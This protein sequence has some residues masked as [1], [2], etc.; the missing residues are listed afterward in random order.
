MSG[1]S[2]VRLST[3]GD[4]VEFTAARAA[5]ALVV[6]YSIP[7]AG[8]ATLNVY[9]NDTFR[10]ALPLTPRY[11]W[12]Y[13]LNAW[14]NGGAS[15]PSQDPAVGTPFHFF[16]EVRMRLDD[17]PA[18]ARVRLQKDV[19]NAAADYTIDLIDL[20]WAPPPAEMPAGFLS[21]VTDCGATPD[22]A[23]DDAQALA[24]CLTRGRDTGRGVWIPP[25]RFDLAASPARRRGFVVDRNTV[26]GAGMWHSV[27]AGAGAGFYCT[28]NDCRF[29]DFALFGETVVRD[30]TAPDNGFQGS[31]GTGSALERVWIEHKK[32]GLWAGLDVQ[33]NGQTD[34]LVVSD[35]RIRNVFADGINLVNGTRNT[36]VTNTHL[37]GTGDD[38]LAQWSYV[39]PGP[40]NRGNR[41]AHNTVQLPWRATCFAVYGGEDA[42][43]EDSLCSDTLTFPG[44][45]IGGP[46]PQLPFGG[47]T[48]VRRNTLTRAGGTSFNQK[49][50]ALKLLAYQVD[51][52]GVLVE[53]VEI[54]DPT[55]FGLEFS[56]NAADASRVVDAVLQ[57][58]T[59]RR[60]GE[61][62]IMVR[63]SARGSATL[64]DVVV[65]A[66]GLGGLRSP[67]GPAPTFRLD[68]GPGNVGF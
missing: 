17:M 51:Q 38:A 31:F 49:F 11:A 67:G 58:V 60:A 53:D 39:Q 46:Y 27:L 43:I 61:Y 21:L 10:A 1:R 7:D 63:A 29:S 5:N 55:Y 34:G 23:V 13:G 4:F 26:Q 37:R 68:R 65:E 18:G 57:R 33:P 24:D 59:I 45:Q 40:V 48:A 6:R 32:V 41:F 15:L 47:T 14:L 12:H 16:D 19:E 64:S 35:C 62:G 3:V 22:D 66:P 28:G 36:T 54:V 52:I 56:A 8:D 9:V 44:L 25:G 42:T 30:D 20:E 2:G 50:G